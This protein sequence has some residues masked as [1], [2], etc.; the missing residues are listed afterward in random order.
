MSLEPIAS[1]PL[2][3]QIH[4]AAAVAALLLGVT[5]LLLA[6]GTRRHGIVG[7]GWAAL[8]LVVAVS[9]LFIHQIRLIGPFSPIH[10]LSLLI[11]VTVPLAVIRARRGDRAGH[12]R[13]MKIIFWLALIGAGLFTMLPGRI[14]GQILFGPQ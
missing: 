6:K 2:V 14:I 7:Y 12:A 9:G 5:Q 11:L 8:M 1:A 10:L 4:A 3:I 13:G